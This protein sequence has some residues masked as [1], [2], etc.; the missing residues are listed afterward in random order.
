MS[1]PAV[2]LAFLIASLYGVAFF[3]LSGRTW[4]ELALYW[5]T[6]VAGFAVGALVSRLIGL[7]LL[8]VGEVNIIE[9]SITSL[10]ALVLVRMLWRRRK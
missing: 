1:I 10:L 3:L 8:P 7:N 4:I 5:V 9:A 2:L 6:A